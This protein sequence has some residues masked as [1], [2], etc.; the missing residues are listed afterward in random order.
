MIWARKMGSKPAPLKQ[1]IKKKLSGLNFEPVL[2]GSLFFIKKKNQRSWEG[3]GKW[4]LDQRFEKD[5][6]TDFQSQPWFS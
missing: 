6:R 4:T 2:T 3:L 5:Q 1:W